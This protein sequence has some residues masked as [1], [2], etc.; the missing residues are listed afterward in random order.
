MIF[1]RG[2][3]FQV[4]TPARTPEELRWWQVAEPTY[5]LS[6]SPLQRSRLV[7]I[8]FI[9]PVALRGCWA[10]LWAE[11]VAEQH[12]WGKVQIHSQALS[13]AWFPQGWRPVMTA[14]KAALLLLNSTVFFLLAAIQE[15]LLREGLSVPRSVLLSDNPSPLTFLNTPF[16]RRTP[17]DKHIAPQHTGKN[18][19]IRTFQEMELTQ[20]QPG[21]A[22]KP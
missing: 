2:L 12:T 7:G 18:R 20:Q 3:S 10:L 8:H 22:L 5:L 13:G 15:M 6:R 4:A 19:A 14:L 16:Q 11:A 21:T 9:P 1:P 17:K